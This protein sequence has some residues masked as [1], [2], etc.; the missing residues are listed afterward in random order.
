MLASAKFSRIF[1]SMLSNTSRSPLFREFHREN[2]L[3]AKKH[4]SL[5]NQGLGRQIQEEEKIS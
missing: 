4:F 5:Y 3:F 1:Y 2:D